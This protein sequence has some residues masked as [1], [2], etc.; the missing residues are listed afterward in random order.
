V[1]L[2]YL[3]MAAKTAVAFVHEMPWGISFLGDYVRFNR[4]KHQWCGDMVLLTN[5]L[6]KWVRG[7]MEQSASGVNELKTTN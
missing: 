5:L 3:A 1:S 4:L 7:V 2:A 6:G